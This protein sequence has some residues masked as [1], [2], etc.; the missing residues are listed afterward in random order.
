MRR[1]F[2]PVP[3]G[4]SGFNYKP[5]T[6]N[7]HLCVTAQA[8]PLLR[9]AARL[10]RRVGDEPRLIEVEMEEALDGALRPSSSSRSLA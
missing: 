1:N 8:G 5:Q 10:L 3:S 6:L 4:L 7:Q 2:L 9:R